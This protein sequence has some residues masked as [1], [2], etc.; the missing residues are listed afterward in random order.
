MKQKDN[1]ASIISSF[2]I[3]IG[4][5]SLNLLMCKLLANLPEIPYERADYRFF[6]VVGWTQLNYP[7]ILWSMLAFIVVTSIGFTIKTME[8]YEEEEA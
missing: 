3:A 5:I 7:G 2:L 8:K 1:K 6:Y 4:V